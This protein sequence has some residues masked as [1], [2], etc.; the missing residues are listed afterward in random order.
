MQSDPPPKED[1]FRPTR[2]RVFFAC[3]LA[4]VLFF[5]PQEI[6]LEWCSLDEPGNDINILEISCS[7]DRAGEVQ[8]LYDLAGHGHRPND[9]IRFLIAPTTY[10]YTYAFPL[11]DAP[12]VALRIA[13]PAKGGTL[14]IRQMRIT[15]RR[16]EEIRRFTRD[17]FRGETEI[18][19]LSP[20]HD[21]WKL[22]STSGASNPMARIELFSPIIPMGKDHRNMLRCLLS[23]G[24]LA[25]MLWILLLAVLFTFYRPTGRSD[26]FS[27]LGFMALLGLVFAFVGNRQLIRNSIHYARYVSWPV[28]PDL[29]LE[30]DLTTTT[31]TSAQLFFDHGQGINESESNRQEFEPH[32]GLQTLRF[33]LSRQPLRAVRFDPLDRMG[34]LVI[35]GVRV[36]DGGQRTCAVLP[37]D[38]LVPLRD[39]TL[40][41][42]GAETLTIEI[43]PGGN[44]PITELTPTALAMVNQAIDKVCTP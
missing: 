4:M 43:P 32:Q 23:T 22:T 42:S 30:F 6:P 18:E 37:L 25:M 44:D 29:L 26:L 1:I 40:L 3:M 24:Y 36:V 2:G 13:P 34:R 21:G 19:A 7:S 9:T 28:K 16:S 17:M 35:R 20:T 14:T 38:S 12:I 39:I 8:I 41:S 5:L 15:N 31:P 33:P 10:T 27:R 11:P